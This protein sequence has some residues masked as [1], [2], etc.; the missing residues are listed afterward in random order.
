MQ[1]DD[2]ACC[3]PATTLFLHKHRANFETRT[4]TNHHFIKFAKSFD[5][6]HLI[7]IRRHLK[8]YI[9]SSYWWSWVCRP[10]LTW[11]TYVKAIELFFFFFA[12]S[13]RKW[14][15]HAKILNVLFVIFRIFRL[16]WKHMYCRLWNKSH[17]YGQ[18]NK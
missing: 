9:Y 11:R 8:F 7:S 13:H 16:N 3:S 4:N 17:C 2:H 14:I 18:E 15:L 10:K 5:I 12:L 1:Y 6:W